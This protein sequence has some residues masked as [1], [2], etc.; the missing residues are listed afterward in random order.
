[1]RCPKCGYTSFAYLETCSKCGRMLAEAQEAFGLYARRSTPPDLTAYVAPPM[2]GADAVQAAN[3]TAA[4]S[5]DL[6]Q[7]D[8][9]GV[10]AMEMPTQATPPPSETPDE[11]AQSTEIEPGFAME[12]EPESQLLGIESA[13][14]AA[15]APEEPRSL[16]IDITQLD[17]IELEMEVEELEVDEQDDNPKR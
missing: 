5:I 8:E 11:P 16:P 6:S 13:A 7:L 12:D 14:D 3:V 15:K 4:L 17:E 1:M 2:E 9:I 10:E